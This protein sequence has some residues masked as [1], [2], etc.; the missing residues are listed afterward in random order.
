MR[1]L[2]YA[3][4]VAIH[5]S[6]KNRMNAIIPTPRELV[7]A[8]SEFRFPPQA[9][10]HLQHLMDLNNEG[11]LTAAQREELTGLVEMS[12]TMSLFRAQAIQLLQQDR[13]T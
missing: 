4:N 3:R 12:E 2:G 8:L 13:G 1:L 9:D 10:A 6:W 11:E 7:E 5:Q